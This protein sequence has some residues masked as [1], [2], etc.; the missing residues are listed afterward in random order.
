MDPFTG[1]GAY[2][3][4]GGGSGSGS[5][6][7]RGGTGADSKG[8]AGGAGGAGGGYRDPFTGGGAYTTQPSES[9]KKVGRFNFIP[10]VRTDSSTREM[11]SFDPYAPS[12]SLVPGQNLQDFTPIKVPQY[13]KQINVNAVKGKIAEFKDSDPVSMISATCLIISATF[14]FLLKTLW[15][16]LAPI[17][18]NQACALTLEESNNLDEIFAH[19]SLPTSI[20]SQT[21]SSSEHYNPTLFLSTLLRWPSEKRFPLIDVA[22]VLCGISGGISEDETKVSLPTG[23]GEENVIGVL[24]D[25]CGWE[26]DWVD[27]TKAR[28]NNTML[29]MRGLA[30]LTSTKEG[31]KRWGDVRGVEVSLGS[32]YRT[33]L[34]SDRSGVGCHLD[35][36]NSGSFGR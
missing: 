17:S 13:Y 11:F 23:M 6:S 21:S 31:K 14:R 1:A 35:L 22:R 4:S 20:L 15:T 5:G 10:Q 26:Q 25:A 16:P 30:N 34:S 27:V 12:C 28:E 32:G 2:T 36:L 18:H 29:V 19:L 8:G 7:R 33:L 9:T 3:G 24:L